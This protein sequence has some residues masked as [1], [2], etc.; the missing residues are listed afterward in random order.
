[1]KRPELRNV[2]FVD[3]REKAAYLDA[4]ASLDARHPAVRT[5]AARIGRAHDPN[6][7][8]GMVRDI[9]RFVRDAIRYVHD[10]R[11]EEFS[12]T[13]VI[14]DRGYG[15]CD[16]KARAFVALCRA[17]GIEARIRPVFNHVGDFVHVQAEV[18][19]RGSAKQP[20]AQPGGWVLAEVTIEG[21]EL[22]QDPR[23]AP[24]DRDGHLRLT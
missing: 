11:Y 4:N 6:D 5:F 23:T 18:R 20:I 16:D 15:D 9:F 21:C 12:D 22:G 7:Q 10:P 17:L 24:R 8:E 1:V 19:W 14:L 3:G 2:H 13:S